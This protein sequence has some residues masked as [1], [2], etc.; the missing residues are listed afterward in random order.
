MWCKKIFHRNKI[1]GGKCEKV[2]IFAPEF[3]HGEIA[4]MARAHDSYS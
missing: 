1:K 3:S 2:Y 4:Q